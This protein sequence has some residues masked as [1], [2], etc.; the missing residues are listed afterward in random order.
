VSP[1]SASSPKAQLRDDDGILK[2]PF[3]APVVEEAEPTPMIGPMAP[4]R[5]P[6]RIARFVAILV[7]L[8]VAGHYF[9][10]GFTSSVP[11]GLPSLPVETA[12][13]PI[14]IKDAGQEFLEFD[15][16]ELPKLLSGGDAPSPG[17]LRIAVL[18]HALFHDGEQISASIRSRSC[19]D[20]M[21]EVVGALVKTLEDIGAKYTVYRESGCFTECSVQNPW[22]TSNSRR[23]MA[24]AFRHCP[25][26]FPPEPSKAHQ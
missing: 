9:S 19:A 15:P 22:S 18:E 16:F 1:N 5:A 23:F 13:G 25:Q 21:T 10:W 11:A 12:P 20:I 3:P 14:R 7:A 8:F 4:Y 2:T 17:N 6:T 26:I 24:L